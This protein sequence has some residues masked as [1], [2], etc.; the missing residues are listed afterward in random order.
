MHSLPETAVPVL[1]LYYQR[2]KINLVAGDDG[3][4]STEAVLAEKARK[5]IRLP[6]AAVPVLNLYYQRTKNPS[7]CRRYPEMAVPVLKVTKVVLSENEN[8]SG[9]RRRQFQY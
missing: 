6:E 7:D 4:S 2:T 1:K 8:P 9:C 5:S 3:R